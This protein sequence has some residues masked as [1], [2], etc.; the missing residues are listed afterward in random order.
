MQYYSQKE[1]DDALQLI[2]S[3][4]SSFEKIV[5]FEGYTAFSFKE[6]N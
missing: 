3:A 6:Q 2:S 1:L 4:I 5:P